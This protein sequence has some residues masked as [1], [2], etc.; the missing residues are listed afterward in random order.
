MG[1]DQLCGSK[2]QTKRPW[3]SQFYDT[4]LEQQVYNNYDWIVDISNKAIKLE[5]QSSI[6]ISNVHAINRSIM[7]NQSL[8][9]LSED[10]F[11]DLMG[12]AKS[13]NEDQI[14][15]LLF[16]S[17]IID[18]QQLLHTKD[19]FDVYQ[20]RESVSISTSS[21]DHPQ[22]IYFTR[23]CYN[24]FHKVQQHI[25]KQL[26][27]PDTV[28]AQLKQSFLNCIIIRMQKDQQLN[29]NAYITEI[30]FFCNL[31][32]EQIIRYYSLNTQGADFCAARLLN[33]QNIYCF[34]MEEIFAD[35]EFYFLLS[36]MIKQ[37]NARQIG[38][39]KEKM[40]QFNKQKLFGSLEP[41]D[42][43]HLTCLDSIQQDLKIM[44][45]EQQ[46][47]KKYK[48][49]HRAIETLSKEV[50]KTTKS[51]INKFL[52]YFAINSQNTLINV[53]LYLITHFVA[54]IP[55]YCPPYI[56]QVFD[57]IDLLYKFQIN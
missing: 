7:T 48:M 44:Q 26:D 47:V 31:C 25:K 17:C 23:Q 54:N 14:K 38:V 49:I 57:L 24:V 50:K 18:D 30:R 5:K 21:N 37:T 10:F 35:Q 42:I 9:D 33:F 36:Y 8:T 56:T 11:E 53:D 29:I 43:P 1:N 2:I 52:L 19:V 32:T 22:R 13:N 41:F 12:S 27:N 51:Q 4:L 20:R 46:P 45:F 28:L 34:V 15:D 16:N 3:K 39:T 40:N 55:H 6:Q